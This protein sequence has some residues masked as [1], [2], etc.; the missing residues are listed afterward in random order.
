[1]HLRR[2]RWHQD[3]IF[4]RYI[5]MPI[6]FWDIETR[7]CVN[8]ETAGAWRYAS[9][10]TTEVLCIGYAVDDGD[11]QIWVPG[12]PVPDAFTTAA[13]DPDW[14]IVAHNHQFERAIATCI[15]TPRSNWPEIPLARQVC[16]MTMALASALPGGLDNAALALGLA[17]QKDREGYQ[18]M[19]K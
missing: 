12:A 6:L 4:H 15:L 1:C 3:A 19:R 11:S 18:L 10:P 13:K 16:T 14:R 17:I 2:G 7:S 5:I 9:D 8:L